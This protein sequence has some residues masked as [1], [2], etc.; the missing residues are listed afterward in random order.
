VVAGSEVRHP[1]A[2]AW[3]EFALVRTSMSVL[4]HRVAYQY[5]QSHCARATVVPPPCPASPEV[6]RRNWS[7]ATKAEEDAVP[8]AGNATTMHDRVPPSP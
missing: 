3:P 7:C 8:L 2:N 1:V 5:A 6:C 4:H